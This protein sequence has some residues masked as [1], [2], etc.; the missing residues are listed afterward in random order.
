M[1]NKEQLQNEELQ[2]QN[3]NFEEEY[4]DE[5][6]AFVADSKFKSFV[7]K[8]VCKTKCRTLVWYRPLRP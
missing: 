8:P 1:S 2:Q 5:N 3:A 4:I 6:V 7:K